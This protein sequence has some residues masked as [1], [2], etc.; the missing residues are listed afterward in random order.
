MDSLAV[1][2]LKTRQGGLHAPAAD[3]L[4]AAGKRRKPPADRYGHPKPSGLPP[5]R[6]EVAF[7]PRLFPSDAA[8]QALWT[9]H[10]NVA[11]RRRPRYL[12]VSMSVRGRTWLHLRSEQ[13]FGLSAVPRARRRQGGSAD[14]APPQPA[15]AADAGPPVT[16][17]SPPAPAGGTATG[18]SAEA[19]APGRDTGGLRAALATAVGTAATVHV[20]GAA[21]DTSL[22]G[23]SEVA[24][25]DD[26]PFDT[27]VLPTEQKR[28]V[29]H[30]LDVSEVRVCT[31]C[32]LCRSR[33]Q[34]VFGEGD[35]DAALMFV[36]EAPG[37]NEDLQGRPFVGR[38]GE[39]LDRQI[40]AMG[41]RRE[42]VYIANVLKCRP[43]GNRAPAPE[44]TVACTPYLVRQI[45]VVRPRVIVTLG[46]PATQY[47][48]RT[49]APMG[50]LRGQWHSYRGIDV[51]PT[52][53]PAYVL[54]NYTPETRRMVWSDLQK[55]MEK[56]GLRAGE[57][58]GNRG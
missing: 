26:P 54:R 2:R 34:T 3:S 21:S 52:Y 57:T 29:L 50:K 45:D 55:V 42:Q 19:L 28:L 12:R 9:G 13:A 15:A 38:A 56:L 31:K 46:L 10:A 40:A 27:P 58:S 35:V 44:E 6:V 25:A 24:P 18:A 20:E 22:F 1:C 30:Q 49:K 16:G 48:L 32:Q 51:M 33:T 17:T 36:G 7:P 53:H 5:L 14:V 43:P 39:L 47:L 23:G 41:L 4:R 11:G 8:S 37:E